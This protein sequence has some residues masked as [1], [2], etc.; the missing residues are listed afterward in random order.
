MPFGLSGAPATFQRLMDQVLRGLPF[1]NAYLYDLVVYSAT[2]EEHLTH[3]ETVMERLKEA[4]LVIQLK[5]CQFGTRECTY[6]GHS[7]GREVTRPE[8]N[9]VKDILNYPVPQTKKAVRSYLGL[10]G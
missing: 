4:G 5:K 10:T 9:K 2:W 6:L 7:I 3:V 8:G 1:T